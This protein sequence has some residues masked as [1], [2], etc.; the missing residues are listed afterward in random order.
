MP[1]D[2]FFNG[3]YG[4]SLKWMRFVL[5]RKL[6]NKELDPMFVG[7]CFSGYQDFEVKEQ[8]LEST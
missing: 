4:N 5:A 8:I 6:F 2:A 3:S 7:L 1:E